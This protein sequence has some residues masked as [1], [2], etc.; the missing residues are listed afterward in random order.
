VR[1]VH[2]LLSGDVAGGEVIALRLARAAKERGHDVGFV[3]P[4]DGPAL[5]AARADGFDVHLLRVTRMY[6]LRDALS[7]ARLL[8]ETHTDVLHTHA[9]V[10][11]N[12]LGR[13]AARSVGVRVISH[14]HIENHFRDQPI[15]RAVYAGLDNAT[16]RLCDRIVAVSE[17][18]RE[19]LIAQGYPAQRVVVIANGVELD[20][21]VPRARSLR[22]ELAI[23]DDVP[24]VGQV[25]RLAEVKG[26]RT[27]IEALPDLPRV[28]VAL[29]GEDLEFEGAYQGE[30]ERLAERLGVAD[31][32]VFAG[33]VPDAAARVAELDVFVL[34]S[35][36]EG[37]S[38]G[39]LEALAHARPVVATP[40]GGTPEV[41]RDGETGL[42]VP[43]RDPQALAAAVRRLLDDP[44]LGRRLGEAGRK[45]VREHHSADVQAERVLA[46]YDEVGR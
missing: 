18:T 40:V 8:R 4:H 27:L 42:L 22:A 10:V 44:E 33:H 12:V 25:A 14:L 7:L 45:L 23:P 2:L 35:H 37:L 21:V 31:R 36:A 46:L 32:I 38:M 41:V 6:R 28:H 3:A 9:Q 30:L 15:A 24:L 43:P 39:L 5:D 34:P 13:L 19:A 1:I 20:G 29:I 11:Q 26:Q 16:A 17:A